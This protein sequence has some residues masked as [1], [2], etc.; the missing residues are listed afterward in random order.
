[1]EDS[2]FIMCLDESD[3][4]YKKEKL[5]NAQDENM[6]MALHGGGANKNSRNRWFDK[7]LQVFLEIF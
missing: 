7:T 4:S 5:K 6:S 1:M 3:K 2:L